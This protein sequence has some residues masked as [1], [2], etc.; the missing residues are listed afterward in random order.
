VSFP[1]GLQSA[2]VFDSHLKP[3]HTYHTMICVKQTRLYCVN[4]MGK[5]GMAVNGRETAGKRQGTAGE[6]QG[7]GRG[8]AGKR[9][10]NGRET[11]GKR[12]GNGRGTAGERLGNGMICVNPPLI[13]IQACRQ[14]T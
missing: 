12:Q 1:F 7:N 2:A 11:A 14:T 6:R 3:I 4:Q 9:Q 13:A 10:G 8:T 5:N